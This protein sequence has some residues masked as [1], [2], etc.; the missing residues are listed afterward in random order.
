MFTKGR[1]VKGGKTKID[2]QNGTRTLI[3]GAMRPIHI[4]RYNATLLKFIQHF[5]SVV[6]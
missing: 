6:N 4:K 2:D 5:K 1:E 3:M